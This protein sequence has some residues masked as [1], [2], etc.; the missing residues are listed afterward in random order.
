MIIE[1]IAVLSLIVCATNVLI[2]PTLFGKSREPYGYE[3]FVAYLINLI[4]VLFMAGK[5]LGWFSF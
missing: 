4:F 1:I 3:S 5:I 2:V